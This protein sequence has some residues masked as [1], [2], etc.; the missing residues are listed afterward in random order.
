MGLKT[1][2]LDQMLSF[3]KESIE[4]GKRVIEIDCIIKE[5]ENEKKKIII[6]EKELN[7]KAHK[8]LDNLFINSS[9]TKIENQEVD[10]VISEN[11]K[12]STEN[13]ESLFSEKEKTETV[14]EDN[15]VE[16]NVQE[17]IMSMEK[18]SEI[19]DKDL[20]V[21][22]K[23]IEEIKIPDFLQKEEVSEK[24]TNVEN[25]SILENHN[26]IYRQR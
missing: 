13:I 24:Q 4:I 21:K 10:I 19:I 22:E 26:T 15:I 12:E 11:E 5:L 3:K 23:K 18:A 8:Q 1:A 16:E 2:P 9:D 6:K 20:D 7:R 14:I 17:D 25:E